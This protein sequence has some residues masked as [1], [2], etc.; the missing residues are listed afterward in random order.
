MDVLSRQLFGRPWAE[1]DLEALQTFVS[2]A[3]EE[4][5][6]LAR[7][8]RRA[9]GRG[10]QPARVCLRQQRAR[11]L[12]A[13]RRGGER[14]RR[15]VALGP[16]SRGRRGSAL[17]RRR[18]RRGGSAAPRLRGEG[19]PARRGTMRRRPPGASGRRAAVLGRRRWCTP[20]C[21]E[22]RCRWTIPHSSPPSM[23]AARALAEP[24][25]CAPRRSQANS[26]PASRGGRCASRSRSGRRRS[27]PTSTGDSSPP[28]STMRSGTS[29]LSI[30]R[31]DRG[32]AWLTRRTA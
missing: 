4:G 28:R 26:L 12:F 19:L 21:P 6:E 22:R 29:A 2:G 25:P 20:A 15:L 18:D 23:G 1:L 30:S 17:G 11:R 7:P 9:R 10:A 32:L 3:R 16:S 8:R 14:G 24:Q 27:R 13:D 31:L 5:G